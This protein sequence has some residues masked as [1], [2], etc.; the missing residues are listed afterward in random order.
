MVF[1][2]SWS[3]YAECSRV[4]VNPELFFPEQT[5]A[6]AARKAKE[7]CGVCPVRVECLRWA[8][9]TGDDYAVLGG[10]T[11]RERNQ[12]RKESKRRRA[13]KILERAEDLKAG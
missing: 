11:P 6:H 13:A 4:D 5:A 1:M 12:V 3:V 7:I 2:P 10:L 8:F 9:K